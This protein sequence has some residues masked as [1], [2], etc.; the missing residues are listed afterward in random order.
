MWHQV[1]DMPDSYEEASCTA[2]FTAS[3]FRGIRFGWLEDTSPYLR[4]AERGASAL[5][6]RCIDADGHLYGVCRGSE[7]SCSPDYYAHRLLPR[8]DDTHGIGIVLIA[9]DEVKRSGA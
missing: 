1:L 7:F 8:L 6:S 4:A 5:Q 9:L 3:F 2:M